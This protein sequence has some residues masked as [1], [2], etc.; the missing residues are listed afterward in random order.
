MRQIREDVLGL[1]ASLIKTAD[2]M[3]KIY[4]A[5]TPDE[6]LELY[7]RRRS[8]VYH[9]FYRLIEKLKDGRDESLAE[10]L[11]S[12]EDTLSCETDHFRK[13]FALDLEYFLENLGENQDRTKKDYLIRLIA[14][15]P[16]KA[17]ICKEA[18]SKLLAEADNP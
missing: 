17:A 14:R 13:L 12:L 16:G 11:Q 8:G 4:L 10:D 3:V 15:C 6:S 18:L 7:L 2:D 9:T 1:L 5:K